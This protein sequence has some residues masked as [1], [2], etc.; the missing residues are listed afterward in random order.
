LREFTPADLDDLHAMDGDADVMR[1]LGTGLPPRTR[2]ECAQALARMAEGYARRPGYG[3]LHASRRDDGSFVGGCGVFPT[4]EGGE[5]EIAYRLRRSCWGHGY[6]TE[7]AAAVL[8][9]AFTTLRLERVIG[10]TWPE[11]AA[12]ARVLRKIGMRPA[13]TAFHY[14][15]EMNQ[16]VATLPAG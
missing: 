12:S 7:M 14:G 11:N 2:G 15:R 3:L 4:P 13:G 9:H 8:A 16:F 5:I 10:L 1:Y 6:A